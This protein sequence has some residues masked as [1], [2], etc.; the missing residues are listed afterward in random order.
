MCGA[1]IAQVGKGRCRRFCGDACKQRWYRQRRQ[2]R[3]AA[4]AVGVYR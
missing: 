3:R 2:R 1:P 4:R